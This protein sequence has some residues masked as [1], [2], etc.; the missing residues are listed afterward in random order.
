M[1]DFKAAPLI[2]HHMTGR[3]PASL[4]TLA[5]LEL[6]AGIARAGRCKI[7]KAILK[8]RPEIEAGAEPLKIEPGLCFSSLP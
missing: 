3:K 2:K 8:I 7:I 1:T 4:S 5:L 6:I